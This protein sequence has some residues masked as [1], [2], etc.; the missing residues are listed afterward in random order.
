MGK[1][2]PPGQSGP[3]NPDWRWLLDR[4][5][6]PLYPTARLFRQERNGDWNG[7]LGGVEAELIRRFVAARTENS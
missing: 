5:D 2:V 3:L 7:V 1:A 4:D 6:S